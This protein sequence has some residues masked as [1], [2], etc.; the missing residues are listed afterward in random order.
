MSAPDRMS[1][2][3]VWAALGAA[4]LWGTTG[5]AQALG[6]DASDPTQVGALRI[7]VGAL[8]LVLLAGTTLWRRPGATRM[9]RAVLGSL[10]KPVLVMAGGLAVAAYQVCFF[11]GVQR[12]GVAVGTVVALGVAP[13]ATG[14]LGIALGEWVTVRWA[15][16]TLAAVAGVVLLVVGQTSGSGDS[17]DA[18]GLLAAVGAGVS[19]AGYTIAARA[20]ILQGESGIRVMALLF[21]VGALALVPVLLGADLSWLW[22]ARGLGM[23]LWLG[24]VATGLAYVLF[25][26]GLSGLPAGSVAT[27]SLA[28]PVTA[29]AL[30]VAVLGERPGLLTGVGM[31]VVVLGLLLMAAGGPRPQRPGSARNRP[32]GLR[33]RGLR[34][35]GLRSRGSRSAGDPPRRPRDSAARPLDGPG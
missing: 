10:P 24:L 4:S 1:A 22:T 30:G 2:G 33:R 35:R 31:L 34:S 17:T 26:R 6:P 7:L 32:R 25:Q 21:V 29:T 12:S 20:L 5:T 11:V 9:A 14:L 27:L 16:S 13:L 18:F 3:A 19:Y 28:E 15:V 23:V 8:A